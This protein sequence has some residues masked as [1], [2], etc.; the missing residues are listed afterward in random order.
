MCIHWYGL[1]FIRPSCGGVYY[2]IILLPTT[3]Y[4]MF[5]FYNIM[6]WFDTNRY[7][8]LLICSCSCNNSSSSGSMVGTSSSTGHQRLLMIPMSRILHQIGTMMILTTVTCNCGSV[9]VDGYRYGR[10]KH[11]DFLYD[12]IIIIFFKFIHIYFFFVINS[13]V[14]DIL[15]FHLSF[16]SQTCKIYTV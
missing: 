1:T 6:T 7:G 13:M 9:V 11:I 10:Y 14:Y 4:L 5:R 16:V 8:L 15:W 3:F 2:V 12:N